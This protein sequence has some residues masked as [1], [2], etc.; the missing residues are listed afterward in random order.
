MTSV[1]SSKYN[2]NSN[3]FSQLDEADDLRP[4]GHR[5]DVRAREEGAVEM[6]VP[7]KGIGVVTDF[8]VET[9]ERLVYNDR[10]Y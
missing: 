5:V 10:L 6:E 7:K 2:G 1:T 9:E 3:G 4:L 8:K